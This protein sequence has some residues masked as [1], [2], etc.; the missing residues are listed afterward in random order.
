[1][2]TSARAAV[3]NG[4]ASE[5]CR[6]GASGLEGTTRPSAPARA[7]TSAAEL[8]LFRR[9]HDERLD[10]PPRAAHR[11]AARSLAVRTS[12]ALLLVALLAAYRP[13]LTASATG[14]PGPGALPIWILLF[15]AYGLYDR[16][17]KRIS[18]RA[19]TTCPALPRA[20]RRLRRFWGYYRPPGAAS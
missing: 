9:D 2:V 11:S 17:I 19:S 4:A 5:L 14:S 6:A 1:M 18:H 3:R 20:A 8:L 16:D 13:W 10:R 7:R 12:V 15:R